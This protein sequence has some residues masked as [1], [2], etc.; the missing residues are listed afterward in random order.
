MFNITF[1]LS[2]LIK[3]E[4]EEFEYILINNEAYF[5]AGEI[6]KILGFANTA[7]AVKNHC[8]QKGILSQD[9]LTA[10][11]VQVVQYISEPNLYSLMFNIPPIK[12]NDT[13]E[14]KNIKEKAER[15][16]WFIFEK[17]IPQIRKTGNFSLVNIQSLSRHTNRDTQIENSKLIN[18]LNFALGGKEK[19]IDYNR[20]NCKAVT[21]KTTKQIKALGKQ[22]GLKSKV[23]N[24]AKEVLRNVPEFYANACTMSFNDEIIASNPKKKLTDLKSLDDKAND[25]FQAMLDEGIKPAELTKQ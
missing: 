19:I 5:K 15:F 9:T 13:D 20:E 25:L 22:L 12:K 7:Q 8:Q 1:Y 21:G 3:F 14:R 16:K 6:C 24:S 18:A 2:M 10:G 11:G 23:C 4:N 17:V